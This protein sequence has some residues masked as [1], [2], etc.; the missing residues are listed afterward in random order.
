MPE[1]KSGALPLGYAPSRRLGAVWRPDHSGGRSAD[2]RCEAAALRGKRRDGAVAAQTKVLG[3]QASTR[4]RHD[5]GAVA[6]SNRDSVGLRQPVHP[7]EDFSCE[8]AIRQHW[9]AAL[10][11]RPPEALV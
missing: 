6:V 11:A 7:I 3:R 5:A 10:A 8:L 1:S 4:R 2:Q 9:T